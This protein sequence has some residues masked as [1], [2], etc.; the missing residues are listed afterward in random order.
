MA[1]VSRF[2]LSALLCLLRTGRHALHGI[3]LVAEG[4]TYVGTGAA[5]I[6]TIKLI[7]GMAPVAT[8]LFNFLQPADA[9]DDITAPMATIALQDLDSMHL[10][11]YGGAA[12]SAVG[13]FFGKTRWR[14]TTGTQYG[15]EARAGIGTLV[16]EGMLDVQKKKRKTQT[17]TQTQTVS[18]Q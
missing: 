10:Y 15:E 2:A 17:Q 18:A 14:L 9:A 12:L 6:R 5:C 13:W 4:A 1:S 11:A 8:V 3:K 16:Q 7:L